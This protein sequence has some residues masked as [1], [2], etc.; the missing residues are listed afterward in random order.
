MT[1]ESELIFGTRSIFW[2]RLHSQKVFSF[3]LIF[4]LNYPKKIGV[5]TEVK[6]NVYQ[7]TLKVISLKSH[8]TV[9]V[10]VSY[11]H[12][13]NLPQTQRL[14]AAQIYQFTVLDVGVQRVK[15]KVLAGLHT[16]WGLK[17]I[18]LLPFPTSGD[19]YIL[20]CLVPFQKWHYSNLCFQPHFSDFDLLD[21]C[22]YIVPTQIIQAS[23]SLSGSS[24]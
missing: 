11:C 21:S 10:L 14:K 17:E 18:H 15:I 12:C 20:W 19:P 2:L 24:L 23:L 7:T 13:S 9:P 16:F 4:R 22:D 5:S 8:T 3:R 6:E 1:W